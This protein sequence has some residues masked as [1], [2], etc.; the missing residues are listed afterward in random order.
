MAPV[1]ALPLLAGLEVG[2]LDA[3]KGGSGHGTVDILAID[4]LGISAFENG[5]MRADKARYLGHGTTV[6]AFTALGHNQGLGFPERYHS[7]KPVLANAL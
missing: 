3:F 4:D 6:T 7:L 2:A 5:G 1:G